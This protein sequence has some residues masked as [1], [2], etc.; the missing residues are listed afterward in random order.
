M[1]KIHMLDTSHNV[2][3]AYAEF[4]CPGCGYAHTLRVVDVPGQSDDQ[5]QWNGD[6]DEPVFTPSVMH[7]PGKGKTCH[8]FVGCNGAQPGEIVFL[9]DSTHAL[10]GKVV[11]LPEWPDDDKP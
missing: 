6:V 8:S 5:W 10:A 11:P 2:Q 9:S 1:A 7:H 4:H 3:N